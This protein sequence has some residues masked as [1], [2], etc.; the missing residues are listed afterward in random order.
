MGEKVR[1]IPTSSSSLSKHQ[2]A[3]THTHTHTLA[4]MHCTHKRHTFSCTSLC[5][6]PKKEECVAATVTF[7]RVHRVKRSWKSQQVTRWL[8]VKEKGRAKGTIPK[9][10]EGK[11]QKFTKEVKERTA[12]YTRKS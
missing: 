10:E 7:S 11:L 1:N 5:F 9:T 4:Y 12:E 2:C 8:G 3:H 6:L